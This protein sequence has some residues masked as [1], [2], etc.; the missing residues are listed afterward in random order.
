MWKEKPIVSLFI[1]R[2]R[3]DR[4]RASIFLSLSLS[5]SLYFSQ[6]SINARKKCFLLTSIVLHFSR[7]VNNAF[8]KICMIHSSPSSSYSCCLLLWWILSCNTHNM[9]SNIAFLQQFW[10]AKSVVLF[11]HQS[12]TQY[13]RL[14]ACRYSKT[15]F[16]GYKFIY[17]FEKIN[18]FDLTKELN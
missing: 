16:L 1:W 15:N 11:H 18:L 12:A 17:L 7:Y 8:N 10:S 2:R 6:I 9:G 4:W 3:R 13:L 5:L 14:I